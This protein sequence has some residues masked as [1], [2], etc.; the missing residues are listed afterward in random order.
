MIEIV[1]SPF[2]GLA[3]SHCDRPLQEICMDF[4]DGQFRNDFFH[5]AVT[6]VILALQLGLTTCESR[7]RKLPFFLR[8]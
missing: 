2:S 8:D 7:T 4:A 3:A 1:V 6:V 5:A